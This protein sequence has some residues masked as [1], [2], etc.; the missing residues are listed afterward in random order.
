MLKTGHLITP[1][2]FIMRFIVFAQAR[3]GKMA[4]KN[5]DQMIADN[6]KL[7]MYTISRFFPTFLYDDDIRQLGYIG[8]WK[9][10]EKYDASLNTKF[11]SYAVKAIRGEIIKH[12]RSLQMQMRCPKAPN[13][14]LSNPM[15]GGDESLEDHISA[16]TLDW[17]DAEGF[18]NAL[19]DRQK[20]IVR[21]RIIDKASYQEIGDEIGISRE[22]VRQEVVRIKQKFDEYI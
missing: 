12:F 15:F 17:I 3:E 11:G 14:S 7:V 16:G 19:T 9:A 6:E 10:C 2:V 13:V 1:I 5:I 22:R 8:L 21:R 4:E 18:Y 20:L